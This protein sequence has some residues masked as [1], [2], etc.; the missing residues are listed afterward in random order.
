MP[1][2]LLSHSSA[3]VP[4][5][6]FTTDLTL[7]SFSSCRRSF[8]ALPTTIAR[9]QELESKS[10]HHGTKHVALHG[11]VRS[12][13]KQKSVAFAALFD[14]TSLDPAQVVLRPDQAER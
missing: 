9:L 11:Y 7:R 1:N 10:E 8:I 2:Q 6:G 3:V 4:R 14:G 12:V 13:R 5:A